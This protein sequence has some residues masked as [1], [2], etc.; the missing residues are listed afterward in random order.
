MGRESGRVPNQEADRA[1]ALRL[2]LHRR[3]DRLYDRATHPA[4]TGTV[5]L[6]L[7]SKQG[8]PGEPE[9]IEREYGITDL[10]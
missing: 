6:K 1:V 7:N 8:R 9:A 2:W 4:F 5:E 3:L 10:Q